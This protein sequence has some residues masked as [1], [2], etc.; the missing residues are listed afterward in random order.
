MPTNMESKYIKRE[1]N[2]SK[3][4]NADTLPYSPILS[5]KEA[6]DLMSG[7]SGIYKSGIDL[8]ETIS[9]PDNH[10]MLVCQDYYVDGELIC[11]GDLIEV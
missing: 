1:A 7:S 8:N 6:I 10:F 9:I 4:L 3:S 11:D 5:I 2:D